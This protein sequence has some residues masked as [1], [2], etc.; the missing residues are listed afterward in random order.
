MLIVQASGSYYSWCW[1]PKC[2]S[3]SPHGVYGNGPQPI[4]PDLLN[5]SRHTRS[6]RGTREVKRRQRKGGGMGI[7]GD[8]FHIFGYSYYIRLRVPAASW[9][10]NKDVVSRT[11]HLVWEPSRNSGESQMFKIT[12]IRSRR[13][14]WRPFS[15]FRDDSGL[16][17]KKPFGTRYTSM[18]ERDSTQA[19]V[20]IIGGK[21]SMYGGLQV[22]QGKRRVCS[23]AS[24]LVRTR[25]HSLQTS[26]SRKT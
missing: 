8:T 11:D 26:S 1:F 5:G 2:W 17:L 4:D 25:L 9:R 18:A 12:G 7:G 3:S 20:G 15:N 22:Q 16:N 24:G 19:T 13:H 6:V 23:Q 10:K 14:T 21:S